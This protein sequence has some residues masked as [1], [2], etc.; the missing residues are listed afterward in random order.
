MRQEHLFASIHTE[1]FVVVVVII[2]VVVNAFSCIFSPPLSFYS[3]VFSPVCASDTRLIWKH[4]FSLCLC[5]SRNTPKIAMQMPISC[6]RWR[7]KISRM[8]Q[9]VATQCLVDWVG[10]MRCARGAGGRVWF[11]SS[12]ECHTSHEIRTELSVLTETHR[13]NGTVYS[14]NHSNRIDSSCGRFT[15][16]RFTRFTL[17]VNLN[18]RSYRDRM[19]WFLL[20]KFADANIVEHREFRSASFNWLMAMGDQLRDGSM[21]HV[22]SF[23]RVCCPKAVTFLRLC[24]HVCAHLE[25]ITIN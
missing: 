6:V 7:K 3:R 24:S 2:I 25:M 12:R 1:V 15:I 18:H 11:W 13:S 20:K 8:L 14:I 21:I 16:S 10:S 5:R 17:W 22:S 4:S 23:Y 19:D 9:P